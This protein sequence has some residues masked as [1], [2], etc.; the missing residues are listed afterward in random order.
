MPT[1][2]SPQRRHKSAGAA[3]APLP[4]STGTSTQLDNPIISTESKYAIQGLVA[5]LSTTR[6]APLDLPEP[7][8][9]YAWPS[10]QSK[11][12]SKWDFK[13]L[14]RLGKAYG[15]FYWL[16]IKNVWANYKTRQQIVRRLNGTSPDT[17]ARYQQAAQRISYNEYEMLLRSNRDLKKLVPFALVFAI[18]GEF[19]PLV[20]VLLGSGVVPATCVIPKQ[21]VQDRKKTLERES[22]FID[23]MVDTWSKRLAGHT[24]SEKQL[25]RGMATYLLPDAYRLHLTPFIYLAGFPVDLY[26]RYLLGPRFYKHSDEILSTAVLVQREGGWSKRSPQDMWEWGNKYGMYSLRQYAK[27]AIDRDEDPVS[28]HMKST[29]LRHFEDETQAIVQQAQRDGD[30]DLQHHDPRLCKKPDCVAMRRHIERVER[31][32]EKEG[33]VKKS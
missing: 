15:K 14:F 1:W 20:I 19:T 13:Y 12:P 24:G 32:R 6:P 7:P 26:W 23:L 25:K 22:T 9:P 5:D 30:P 3:A 10:S 8:H 18:C 27:D 31:E 16:G 21:L 17:A 29:L 28:E 11:D 4:R 2:Q 33:K